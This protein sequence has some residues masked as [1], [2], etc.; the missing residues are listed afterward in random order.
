[1]K[2]QAAQCLLTNPQAIVS[3]LHFIP[4]I[5]DGKNIRGPAYKFPNG[6]TKDKFLRGRENS[7]AW[8]EKYGSIYR[9]WAGSTPEV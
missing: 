6:N 2:R 1:M 5:E 9:I 8:N 7:Y 3:R 4:S